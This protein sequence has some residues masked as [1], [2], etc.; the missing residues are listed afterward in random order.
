LKKLKAILEERGWEVHVLAFTHVAASNC[1]GITILRELHSKIQ[2][3]RAAILIDEMSMVSIKLWAALSQMK[4]TGSSFWIFGDCQGQFLPI[5]D[6]HRAHLLDNLDTSNFMHALCN[7]LR[8]EV[9]RYRR[10]TD[11]A[12]FDFVGQLY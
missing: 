10:G 8:V 7:G 1:G 2:C 4:M 11:Q 3:K 5:Q 6:Q 12:H 9:K